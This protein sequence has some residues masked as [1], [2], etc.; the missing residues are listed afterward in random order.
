MH[1]LP[2]KKQLSL[3]V[4][5]R[6]NSRTLNQDSQIKKIFV[7]IH[8]IISNRDVKNKTAMTCENMSCMPT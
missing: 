4:L 6:L 2:K 5:N 7:A 8:K 3:T 1:K